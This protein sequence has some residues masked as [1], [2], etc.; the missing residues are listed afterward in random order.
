[1]SGPAEFPMPVTRL[2]SLVPHR[3]PMVWVDEVVR[4]EEAGGECRVRTDR[5]AHYHGQGG[6]RSTVIVEWIAQSYA[7][8]RAAQAVCRLPGAPAAPPAVFYLAAIRDAMLAAFPG[9]SPSEF[10]VHVRR[11]RSLGPLSL[12]EG[13]V[14]DDRGTLFGTAFLKVYAE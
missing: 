3:P 12:I 2:A 6:I 1:M 11:V 7:Y 5:H 8:V 14:T 13:R 10:R 4:V 9:D